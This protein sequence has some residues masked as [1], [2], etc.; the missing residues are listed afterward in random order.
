MKSELLPLKASYRLP[1]TGKAGGNTDYCNKTFQTDFKITV[2]FS[3]G[4]LLC[5]S[6]S[7][8]S[9]RAEVALIRQLKDLS[10]CFVLFFAF[11]FYST[12]YQ[13]NELV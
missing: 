1:I 8:C 12:F 4:V 7:E 3:T 5:P 9:G 6:L 13:L 2:P 10:F 11:I